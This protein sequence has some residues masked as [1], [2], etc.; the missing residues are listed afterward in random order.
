MELW[1]EAE[2]RMRR[3]DAMETARRSRLIRLAE[4]GRSKSVRTRIADGA[5]AMSDALA[6]LANSLRAEV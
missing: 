4:S 6:V 1:L 2:I 3:D 5:Q